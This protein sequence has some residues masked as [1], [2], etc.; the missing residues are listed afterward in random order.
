M[1]LCEMIFNHFEYFE[2]RR[3]LIESRVVFWLYLFIIKSA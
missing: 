3:D 1:K 2:S